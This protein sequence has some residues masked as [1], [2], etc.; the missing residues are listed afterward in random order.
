LDLKSGENGFLRD[1]GDATGDFYNGSGY[2]Y[3]A[4]E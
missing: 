2:G 3:A 1:M 4:A